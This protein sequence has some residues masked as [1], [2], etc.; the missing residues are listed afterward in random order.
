[1]ENP[2]LQS[3]PNFYNSN[4]TS[5]EK[6]T[7][8]Q[9]DYSSLSCSLIT[10]NRIGSWGGMTNDKTGDSRITFVY[11]G[12]PSENIKE[13]YLRDAGTPNN[14]SADVQEMTNISDKFMT[15]DE[16]KGKYERAKIDTNQAGGALNYNEVLL[17]RQKIRHESGQQGLERH[18][19][20]N[21]FIKPTALLLPIIA[22][23]S[24]QGEH[25]QQRV[26]ET[27][28]VAKKLGIPVIELNL[29]SYERQV[30]PFK[31]KPPLAFQDRLRITTDEASAKFIETV[32]ESQRR[33]TM[34]TEHEFSRGA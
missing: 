8:G 17:S 19:D 30:V 29:D 14:V 28:E 33:L 1:M 2:H 13:S 24:A 26:Q 34:N 23:K 27:Y 15:F 3:D 32:A 10:S 25:Y 12:I 6:N 16:L 11:N 4:F 7:Q 31:P 9:N 18:I 20:R 5:L 22:D 21:E